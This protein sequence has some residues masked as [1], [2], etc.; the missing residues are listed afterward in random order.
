VQHSSQPAVRT[1]LTAT[2]ETLQP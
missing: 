2:R 1:N